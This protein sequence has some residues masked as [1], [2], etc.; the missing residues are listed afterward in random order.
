IG[1]KYSQNRHA[2]L[3]VNASWLTGLFSAS[4]VNTCI[5]I[6]FQEGLYLMIFNVIG[7]WGLPFLLRTS[8][9]F[10]FI[11]N[12]Y[13]LMGAIAINLIIYFDGGLHAAIIPWLC[14][15]PT[16]ALLV[17][18]RRIAYYW[19]A[20][21][22]IFALLFIYLTAIGYPMPKRYNLDFELFFESSSIIGLVLIVFVISIVFE[23]ATTKAMKQVEQKNDEI[24]VQN[25][26]LHQQQEEIIAQRDALQDAYHEIQRKNEDILASINY[27]RRIQKA[28]LPSKEEIDA[29][30]PQ[31]F[32]LFKPRDIVSGDFYWCVEKDKRKFIAAADCTG[33]GI[34]GAFMSMIG[35][36]M[37][38]E[39][40]VSKDIM[41]ADKILN[42][43]NSSINKALRQDEGENKD[44]MDI[45]LCVF[46]STTKELEYAGAMNPIIY[47]QN[48]ELVELKATKKGVGGHQ[49]RNVDFQGYQK[50]LI[51]IHDSTML[52][53][54]SDGFQDQ[55]GGKDG[56]KFMIKNLRQLFFEIYPKP[57]QEQRQILKD[58]ITNWM[59][60]DHKQIDDILVIGVRL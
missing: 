22:L 49:L 35:V 53:L 5:T 37:L 36:E 30:F 10:N 54:F 17:V 57:P 38:N 47:V 50:H 32:V 42:K 40:V 6:D 45:A 19:L 55:F 15:T 16:L 18:G 56:R 23:A 58:T 24:A 20:I 27:A 59:S 44:G 4:Y 48:N 51:P 34:P 14:A 43:L 12:L 7:Y 31:N 25:E 2:Q 9:P 13:V 29:I 41:E 8:L 46:H 28:L 1:D 3:L 52:Y 26:E 60:E 11:G 39:I 21:S 33:H